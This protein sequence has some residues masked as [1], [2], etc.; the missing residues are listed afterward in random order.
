MKTNYKNIEALEFLVQNDLNEIFFEN[1]Q[2]HFLVKDNKNTQQSTI[3]NKNNLA[4]NN[5]ENMVKKTPKIS[6]A[7]TEK[8]SKNFENNQLINPVFSTSD[9]LANL[10]KKN[11]TLN[12]SNIEKNDSSQKF[13]PLNEII[14]LAK[15][16]ANSCQSLD[17]L[18]KAVE[19]FEGCNL[20][21]IATNTVFCDGNPQSK[22]MVIGEAPGNHEDLQGIP[23]C[24]DSGNML[25]EMLSAI[26]LKRQND[27]YVTNVIFWRPP[28]NRRPTDE[29]LAICR[30]FVERHIA[31]F[32][33]KVIIL[34]GA[35]AMSAII[36]LKDPITKVRGQFLDYQAE[37]LT[38][39]AKIFTIFHPSF[40]M[41]QPM[42]KKLAWQDMLALEKF[43]KNN[44]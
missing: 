11:I 13:I 24:G 14:N 15:N 17:Q 2:N 29:E 42:K 10:A 20:K 1:P 26:N 12:Q 38:S 39:P 7:I 16:T 30:P 25:N 43:I 9:A 32:A 31:L 19:E 28:G 27:F 22:I 41:R 3:S 4:L 40:L 37:F 33:P 5:H 36:G 23:F 34:V 6:N 44:F 8:N 35:T 21:K 18:K